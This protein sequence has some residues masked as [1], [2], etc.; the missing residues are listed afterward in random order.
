MARRTKITPEGAVTRAIR[1]LL[2]ACGVYHWKV[3]QGLGSA[4]GVSDILGI[5]EGRLLAI[6]IKAPGKKVKP[7]SAQERF[8]ENIHE[9]GGIAIE[10]DSVQALI[11]RFRWYGYKLPILF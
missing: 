6:E 9:H 2:A 1:D 5:Y 8:L 7:G 11:D 4:P 3:H 10:A